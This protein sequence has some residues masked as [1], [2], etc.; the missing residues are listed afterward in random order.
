MLPIYPDGAVLPGLGFNVKWSPLF[1]N[2]P[3]QTSA[4]GADIDVGL[5]DTPLHNFE[6]TYEFLRDRGP[7]GA[8]TLEF[9]TMMGFFLQLGGTVGR[10]AFKNVDDHKVSKQLVGTG[11]GAT[12]SFT[13]VRTFGAQGYFGTEPVGIVDQTQPFRVYV[14]NSPTPLTSSQYTLNSTTPCEQT[15]TLS[16]APT[17][18]QPVQVDMSYFYY[19]KF[20]DN[21]Y[22]F[23]KFMDRLWLLNK[24]DIHSCR[25]A[26]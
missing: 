15:V 16:V 9:K 21:T 25:P 10:F 2:M 18:G 17:A 5:A 14:G 12:T 24:I 1:F 8:V 11:D 20:R 3:T 26:A 13:L 22:T 19:C 6:L 23:E 7:D 4:T